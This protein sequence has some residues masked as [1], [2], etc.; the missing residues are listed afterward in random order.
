MS[1]EVYIVMRGR[2]T[3][4]VA[5]EELEVGPGSIVS[6][7]HG[8]EHR[9]VRIDEDLHMLVVFAPPDEED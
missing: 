5:D 4:R 2:G 3:L 6:V 8:E 7:D 1:D 9:F